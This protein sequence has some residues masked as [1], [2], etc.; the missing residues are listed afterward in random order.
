MTTTF[1]NSEIHIVTHNVDGEIYTIECSAKEL[2]NDYYGDCNVVPEN[3]APVYFFAYEG[4]AVCPYDYTNFESV[5]RYI[6]N[7]T[8]S[9]KTPSNLT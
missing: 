7:S 4:E 8:K 9:D 1:V 3:D 2:L 6:L 5:V